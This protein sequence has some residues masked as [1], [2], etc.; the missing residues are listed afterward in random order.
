MSVKI[1]TLNTK[2]KIIDKP[3]SHNPIA[4][5]IHSGLYKCIVCNMS[6]AVISAIGK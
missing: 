3:K 6:A 4:L 1:D 2:E 5:C